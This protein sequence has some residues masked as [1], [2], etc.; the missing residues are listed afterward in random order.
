MAAS[1]P[2][3]SVPTPT[4]TL[5][6]AAAFSWDGT[7]WQPAGRSM[8][9][10]AT[11]TGTLQGVAPFTWSGSTWQAGGM[12]R[13]GVPTPTGTLAGVAVYTWNGS[14]WVPT[15][16]GTTPTPTGTLQ[17]V[18][19]FF[20]DGSAWQPSGKAM[21]EVAIPGGVLIGVAMFSWNGSAWVPAVSAAA[22]DLNFLMMTTL[23]PSITFTRG[24]TATYFDANGLMQTAGNNVPRFDHDPVTLAP[25]GLLVEEAR[26]NILLQSS[27]Q[28]GWIVSTGSVALLGNAATGPDGANSA[29]S[30]FSTDTTNTVRAAETSAPV[31]ASASTAYTVSVFMRSSATPTNAYIQINTAGTVA[32]GVAYF[33]L[34]NGLAV[35]GADL[36]GGLTAKSATI[37][38]VG[39]FWRVSFTFTTPAGATALTPYI[40]PCQVVSG[41]GDNRSYTGVIGQGIYLFGCQVEAGAFVTSYIP[42]TGTAAARAIDVCY[43]PVGSWFNPGAFS[44]GI[45]FIGPSNTN[46]GGFGG[47]SD[48]TFGNSAYLGIDSSSNLSAAY[49][50]TGGA[51]TGV[52][53]IVKTAV[54]KACY[55]V[56]TTQ[57][58][59]V[60]NGGSVAAT[61]MSTTPLATAT[62]LVFG[63]DPWSMT[64]AQDLWIRRVRCWPR[65]LSNTEL[66]QVTT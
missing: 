47:F 42:T 4:G 6:G 24:S 8:S 7:T 23:D 59:L 12:S 41:T 58:A 20:W 46:G 32:A 57:L 44:L 45:D 35:V 30:L 10:V 5:Q 31:T 28:S 62:R 22:L 25:Q 40:G 39:A 48:G 43:I 1:D 36:L 9:F 26:T 3:S 14:A 19:A 2:T 16:G 56:A 51:N 53:V 66:Q 38:K 29:A 18:A 65:A 34:I 52:G 61:P 17:G 54:N 27:F 55:S 50:P 21:P 37:S 13:P 49:T 60:V 11:P 63:N 64:T 15:G 33:D